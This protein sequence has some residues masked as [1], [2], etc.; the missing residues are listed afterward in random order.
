[1]KF[2][3]LVTDRSGGSATG[4]LSVR[5]LPLV[6]PARFYNVRLLVILR[7]KTSH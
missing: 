5:V 4:N 2:Q 3:L 7:V 6:H 1:L